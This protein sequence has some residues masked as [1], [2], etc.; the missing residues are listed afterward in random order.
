MTAIHDYSV[1]RNL[2]HTDV[3]FQKLTHQALSYLGGGGEFHPLMFFFHHLETAQA[4]TL[5]LSDFKYTC[6]RYILQVIR[7][8]YILR[9]YHGNKITKGTLQNLTQ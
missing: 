6:L 7:G 3:E 2:L 1:G 5:K 8:C 9:C 4:M